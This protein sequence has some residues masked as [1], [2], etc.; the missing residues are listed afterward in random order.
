TVEADWERVRDL[1]LE[2]LADT[3]IAYVETRETALAHSESE[4]RMRANRGL[5]EHGTFLVAVDQN[6]RWIGTMSGYVP[7]TGQAQLVGVYVA[8]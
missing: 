2:M 8:P 5:T 4:W 3:P 1:R 6:N 7:E